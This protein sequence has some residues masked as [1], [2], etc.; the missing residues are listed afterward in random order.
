[1][2]RPKLWR[3]RSAAHA[4]LSKKTK[5]LPSSPANDQTDVEIISETVDLTGIPSDS[6]ETRW[7]GGVE[8]ILDS[9]GSDF[10]WVSSDD[11]SD[12]DS[13][14]GGISDNES[15]PE[16][17]RRLQRNIEHELELLNAPSVYEMLMKKR[18]QPEWKKAESNRGFGYTGNSARTARRQDKK[19]RD[20]EVSDAKSRTT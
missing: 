3:I 16:L 20:K 19:A 2:G 5:I 6:E 4:R 9:D 13:D 8:N 11:E 7:T 10:S 15:D 14:E 12:G 18:T 1:M 17:E